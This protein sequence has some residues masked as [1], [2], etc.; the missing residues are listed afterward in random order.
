MCAWQKVACVYAAETDG[1]ARKSKRPRRECQHSRVV[2]PGFAVFGCSFRDEWAFF[3]GLEILSGFMCCFG[4]RVLFRDLGARGA[5]GECRDK[6]KKKGCLLRGGGFRDLGI[7]DRSMG[8]PVVSLEG[9]NSSLLGVKQCCR[10]VQDAGI[11]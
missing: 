10:G 3:R 1:R 9:E 5:R 2:F 8:E 6:A 11:V 4:I 7:V